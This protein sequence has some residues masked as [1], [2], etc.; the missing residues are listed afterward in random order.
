MPLQR[1]DGCMRKVSGLER[2]RWQGS[3]RAYTP[4][5]QRASSGTN[6]PWSFGGLTVVH[7]MVFLQGQKH[8]LELRL[9]THAPVKQHSHRTVAYVQWHYVSTAALMH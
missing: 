9:R 8:C 6:V 2:A 4:D 7:N 1:V 3:P 5:R